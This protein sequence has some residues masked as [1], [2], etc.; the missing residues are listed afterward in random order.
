L[1]GC[2]PRG[3]SL[4]VITYSRE[5]KEVRGSEHSHSQGNSHFGRGSPGGLPKLQSAS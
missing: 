5:S 1:E 3:G 4:R 2:G